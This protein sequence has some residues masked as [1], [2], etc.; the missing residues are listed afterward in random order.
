MGYD[1]IFS[2]A[3][4]ADFYKIDLANGYISTTAVLFEAEN[5]GVKVDAAGILEFSNRQGVLLYTFELSKNI[6]GKEKY[7]HMLCKVRDG[8]LLFRF[9]IIE[10]ID[11]Y[12]HCD[13]EHDRWDS[14]VIGYHTVTYT[15][16]ENK[17]TVTTEK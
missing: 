4:H 10:W 12:P 9:P 15:P 7:D 2:S 5:I 6:G 1:K 11:N 14:K 16:T 17:A 13:G 3:E 8:K